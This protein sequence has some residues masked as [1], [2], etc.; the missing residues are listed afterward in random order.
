MPLSERFRMVRSASSSSRQAAPELM[1]RLHLPDPR[2]VWSAEIGHMFNNK[3]LSYYLPETI[4]RK[5]ELDFS[6]QG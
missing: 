5:D 6:Y 2:T 3:T 1:A 4:S